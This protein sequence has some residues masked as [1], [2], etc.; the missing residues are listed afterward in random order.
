MDNRETED[1]SR[2]T[3]QIDGDTAPSDSLFDDPEQWISPSELHE[4]VQVLRDDIDAAQQEE[5]LAQIQIAESSR[6]IYDLLATVLEGRTILFTEQGMHCSFVRLQDRWLYNSP[7]LL[8]D[9]TK[10]PV[11]VLPCRSDPESAPYGFS[12]LTE[13]D[14]EPY[15][16]DINAGV[17]LSRIMSDSW[18]FV[19]SQQIV[20]EP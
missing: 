14:G 9:L 17:L 6:A 2:N 7:S 4:I 12:L 1:L 8:L 15:A 19:N 18:R 3:D 5:R 13:I 20:E 16:H 11:K 10:T